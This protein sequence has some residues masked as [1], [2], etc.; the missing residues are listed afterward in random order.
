MHYT[1]C[2][3]TGPKARPLAERFWV[4][5]RKTNTCWPWTGAQ[6]PNGYGYI[7]KLDKQ[8]AEY[9][10][11]VARELAF[12]P[13]PNGMWVC[14][15]CDNPPCVRPD[16]LF[17]GTVGDNT[18][19]AANKKRM[20]GQQRTHCPHGHEFTPE[21]TYL[22]HGRGHRQCKTCHRLRY[23]RKPGRAKR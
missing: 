6:L 7:W 20:R 21:N 15:Y 2:M 17:L 4:K 13:I 5:V 22:A 8:H 3:K 18:R 12:G 9:A 16:H 23:H 14:H 1:W 19:D 10:H 11:R